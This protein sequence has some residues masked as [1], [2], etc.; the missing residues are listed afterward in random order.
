M[1]AAIIWA[2]ELIF[3]VNWDRNLIFREMISKN[4][5]IFVGIIQLLCN[6]DG[7]TFSYNLRFQ[8]WDF[9]N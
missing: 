6:P 1:V 7:C 3:N 2:F 4:T 8:F 5:Q 9:Y